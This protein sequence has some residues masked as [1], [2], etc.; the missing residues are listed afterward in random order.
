MKRFLLNLFTAA[1]AT[2]GL[3]LGSCSDDNDDVF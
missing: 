3:S 2:A 1:L